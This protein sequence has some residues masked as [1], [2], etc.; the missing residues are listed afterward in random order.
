M[1]LGMTPSKPS[2]AVDRV[3]RAGQGAGAEGEAV[4]A[5]APV[6]EAVPVALQHPEVREE[7]VGEDHRLRVLEVGVAR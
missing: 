7:V 5:A 2:S 4:G 6:G 1:L 3:G